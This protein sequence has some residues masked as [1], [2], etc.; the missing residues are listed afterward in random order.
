VSARGW[1][2]NLALLARN[3]GIMPERRVWGTAAE[4]KHMQGTCAGAYTRPR[5]SDCKYCAAIRDRRTS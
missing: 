4:A 5:K 2:G 1:H 3:H